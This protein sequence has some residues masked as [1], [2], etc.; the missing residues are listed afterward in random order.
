MNIKRG[1]SRS[2]KS[3]IFC[4]NVAGTIA[5]KIEHFSTIWDI[6]VVTQT[7]ILHLILVK[8]FD[9]RK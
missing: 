9:I 3:V 8:D 5:P 2:T 1:T 7:R 4:K 6:A